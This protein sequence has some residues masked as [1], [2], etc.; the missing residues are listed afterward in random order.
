MLHV[1]FRQLSELLTGHNTF[2]AEAV[3]DHFKQLW[4]GMSQ[5]T[6][7]TITCIMAHLVLQ[8]SS[9]DVITKLML[10]AVT[11]LRK[12]QISVCEYGTF[13]NTSIPYLATTPDGIIS[14]NAI[15]WQ[16]PQPATC[17]LAASWEKNLTG[18]HIVSI[19]KSMVTSLVSALGSAIHT[20]QKSDKDYCHWL[21]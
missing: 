16:E 19:L 11:H 9:E 12:T 7:S 2:T 1:A 3:E 15:S 14:F 20:C 8:Q 10:F 17:Q 13:L 21:I 6:V 5:T 18:T 4:K